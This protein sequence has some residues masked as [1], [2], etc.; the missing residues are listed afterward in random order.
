VGSLAPD[1][2]GHELAGPGAYRE[3]MAGLFSGVLERACPAEAALFCSYPRDAD[4]SPLSQ[5]ELP[6]SGRAQCLR[7]VRL[8]RSLVRHG[9][10]MPPAWAEH[11]AV[12]VGGTG[13]IKKHELTIPGQGE[14]CRLGSRQPSSRARHRSPRSVR[15]VPLLGV[16]HGCTTSPA[17]IADNDALSDT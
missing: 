1:G 5:T 6:R 3:Q 8:G 10:G 17:A 12:R 9:K 16:A 2:P 4:T 15:G 11:P 7:R 14:E 13:A